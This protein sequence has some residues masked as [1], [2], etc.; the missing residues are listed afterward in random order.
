MDK[1]PQL[2]WRN[3]STPIAQDSLFSTLHCV[4]CTS[5]PRTRLLA[6]SSASVICFTLDLSIK[7]YTCQWL[8]TQ[9]HSQTNT[10]TAWQS[11]ANSNHSLALLASIAK[12]KYFLQKSLQLDEMRC[13]RFPPVIIDKIINFFLSTSSQKKWYY[14]VDWWVATGRWVDP[15]YRRQWSNLWPTIGRQINTKSTKGCRHRWKN[16]NMRQTSKHPGSRT[17]VQYIHENNGKDGLW[18]IH[19]R[20]TYQR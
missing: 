17:V 6:L 12:F 20:R 18:Q 15:I 9:D 11:K 10:W 19:S 14:I 7:I 8:W 2:Q 3:L 5:R 16:S 4:C 13:C 1:F